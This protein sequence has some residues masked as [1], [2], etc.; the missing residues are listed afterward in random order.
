MIPLN[1]ER[2]KIPDVLRARNTDQDRKALGYLLDHRK[3]Q[4]LK[5]HRRSVPQRTK[6]E[7]FID[8]SWPPLVSRIYAHA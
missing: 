4:P 8:Q 2:V 5:R 6:E 3:P 1:T 7:Q